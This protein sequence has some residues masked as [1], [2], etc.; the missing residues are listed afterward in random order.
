MNGGTT[1]SVKQSL[2]SELSAKRRSITKVIP[3]PE[4]PVPYKVGM[5]DIVKP[6][7]A[8]S[9]SFGEKDCLKI[10]PGDDFRM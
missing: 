10:R 2:E 8:D 7:E 3:D 9:I 6:R 4:C 1:V 5:I